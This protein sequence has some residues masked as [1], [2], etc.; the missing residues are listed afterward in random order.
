MCEALNILYMNVCGCD[1]FS[2][3]SAECF[4]FYPTSAKL[5][6]PG[7]KMSQNVCMSIFDV[8]NIYA[9]FCVFHLL[10]KF[11]KEI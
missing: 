3:K 1:I 9:F 2:P 6:Q 4:L 8:D 7:L 5:L 10:G 11:I